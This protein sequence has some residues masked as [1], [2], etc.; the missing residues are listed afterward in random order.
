MTKQITNNKYQTEIKRFIRNHNFTNPDWTDL[1]GGF[2]NIN[3]EGLSKE[4]A[5]LLD[6]IKLAWLVAD[7]K[8]SC[9]IYKYILINRM[10]GLRIANTTLT[11][12]FASGLFLFL[13]S[14]T[15]YINIKYNLGIGFLTEFF[16]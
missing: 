4:E 9:T 3:E 14:M 16:A 11:L 8:R 13:I 2:P 7:E 1:P 12:F 15:Y 6:A 10:A 5:H